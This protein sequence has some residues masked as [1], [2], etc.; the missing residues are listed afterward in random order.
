M[1]G[2]DVYKTKEALGGFVVA[3]GDA[4]GVLELVET[5]PDQVAQGI[6]GMIDTDPHLA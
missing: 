5:A 6:Q 1:D 4:A 2:R 3:G